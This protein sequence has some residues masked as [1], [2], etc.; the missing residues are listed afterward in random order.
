M[1]DVYLVHGSEDGILSVF[2]NL[3]NA[4]K[5]ALDYVNDDGN[6][7]EDSGGD[8]IWWFTNGYDDSVTAYVMRENVRKE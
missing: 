5:C 3:K 1:R 7:F 2:S 4:K 8:H 6:G